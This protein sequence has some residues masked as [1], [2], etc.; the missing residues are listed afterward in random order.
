ME[1]NADAVTW[2]KARASGANGGQCVEIGTTKNCLVVL[3][4][5]TKSRERGHLTV[6]LGTFQRFIVDITKR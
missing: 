3:I 2:R 4:R 6:T 5:D 1:G